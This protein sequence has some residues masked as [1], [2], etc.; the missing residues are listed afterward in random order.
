MRFHYQVSVLKKVRRL[1]FI[2]TCT[3]SAVFSNITGLTSRWLSPFDN[4][5]GVTG[6]RQDLLMVGPARARNQT[7][8]PTTQFFDMHTIHK[9][10][11]FSATSSS[12][13][14]NFI[15]N[16]D[17]MVSATLELQLA[18]CA[19]TYLVSLTVSSIF[20]RWCLADCWLWMVVMS[21]GWWVV[22]LVVRGCYCYRHDL[23]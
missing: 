6:A 20:F 13:I 16:N 15:T 10:I 12:L 3:A 11:T 21:M 14:T 18:V 1:D 7:P 23:Q 19:S 8:S 17:P 22:S 2:T 4:I 9:F 5:F